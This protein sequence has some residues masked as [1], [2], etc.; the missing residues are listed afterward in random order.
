MTEHL[1]PAIFVMGPTAAGKTDLAVD[2]AAEL[3]VALISVDS[4]LVY[5]GMNIGT[6]KPEPELLR[7][8]PHALVDICEPEDT[9]SAARFRE[10]ALAEMKKITKK[11]RIPLLVGG[12]M[13]YFRALE[14]GLS[15]L[16]PSDPQVRQRLQQGLKAE[17]LGALHARL[18]KLDPV[19]AGRIH[20][21]DPQRILRALEVIELSGLPLS[22]LQA[23][24]PGSRLPYRVIKLIRAPRERAVLHERIQRRFDAMLE[25]GFEDEVR[26]LMARPGFSE[27]LPSMRAVGYRQMIDYLQGRLKWEEMRE[28][29][30]IATR[31]LAKRQFTWLRRELDA[32]WLGEAQGDSLQESLE[33]IEKYGFN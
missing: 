27:E 25:L 13:L 32:K 11:G 19:A 20:A 24:N 16:P 5:R 23:Q 8:V 15:E 1:P 2:L 9:Y 10:D 3:P 6:A 29:G 26:R 7:R 17:G 33:L 18:E 31:Q 22:R 21:N 14:H 4:A 28:R 12:T 30:I